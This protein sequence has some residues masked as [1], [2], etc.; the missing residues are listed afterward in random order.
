MQSKKPKKGLRSLLRELSDD[1]DDTVSS[2]IGSNISEDP[3]RPWLLSFQV[4]MD[5]V[6]QVPDGW[7]AIRWWGVSV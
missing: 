5:A 3:N 1:D 7:D 2:N 6:E 4:Y